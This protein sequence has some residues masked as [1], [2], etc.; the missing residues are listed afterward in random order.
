MRLVINPHDDVSL[1]RV[2]NV[3][4]R[5][6]GKGVMDAVEKAAPGGGDDLPLLAAG[7]QPALS[8]NSLWARVVRGL[9]ERVLPARAAASL[10]V[11]RDLIVSLTEVARSESVSIAIGKMLDQSGYLRDLHDERS[12]EAE[13]R[14]ENLAGLVSAARE[15]ESRHAEPSLGGFVDRLSLLSDAD[16]EQGSRDARV[17]LMT[18]HSAKGLEFP[19]VILAGLEEGLFPHS[20]SSADEEELEEERRLC[21]VGMTRARSRLVLTGA[22]RRRVFGEYQSSDPSRFIDEVPAQLIDRITPLSSSPSHGSVPHYEFRTNP[23]GRGRRVREAEP[24]YA[25][26]DEDQS[27]GFSLRPGLR[28]RH[29]QFGIGTVISV[30]PLDDDTKLV[31][32]FEAV[33]RK[34][35]R[36]RY[37]RLEPA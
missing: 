2:I 35:L 28:V 24:T 10:A 22:A 1:R 12:E 23:Y 30:D 16:E 36:A 13:G 31:V 18:L 17:W 26:E 7:L 25:Y 6:I 8:A 19:V 3:P 14:I 33:G 9:D 32:R 11:F 20:R 15:Y 4:A 29:P 21:Y 34:T 37:A 27:A 5:G